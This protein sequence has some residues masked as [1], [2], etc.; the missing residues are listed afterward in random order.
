VVFPEI[1][2]RVALQHLKQ[3]A[4]IIGRKIG[5]INHDR[6][7][8][9]NTRPQDC[10]RSPHGSQGILALGRSVVGYNDWPVAAVETDLARGLLQEWQR[11][12]AS[13]RRNCSVFVVE[14]L[15]FHNADRRLTSQ[16][17]NLGI[18]F[19]SGQN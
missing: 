5:V 8:G 18:W 14:A 1:T 6:S 16:F 7:L 13:G 10:D 9:A 2:S 12:S 15:T 3:C 19:K 11:Q 4:E 17:H